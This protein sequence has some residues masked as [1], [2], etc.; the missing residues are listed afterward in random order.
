V[1]TLTSS[2][3][4]DTGAC[5][6]GYSG[7]CSYACSL[8]TWTEVTNTCSPNSC[9]AETDSN[10]VLALTT[11]GNTDTGTCAA[12]YT[13]ACSYSCNLGTWSQVTNTC[14]A[15]STFCI[16]PLGP[17]TGATC[18][19]SIARSPTGASTT[20]VGTYPPVPPPGLNPDGIAFDGTNMW[21]VDFST[22]QLTEYGPT[23]TTL[24]PYSIAGS[25]QIAIAFDGT[26]M[27][28]TAPGGGPSG[29]GV[30]EVNPSGVTINSFNV[31]SY[32]DAI[33]FD[34][35]NMWIANES[36]TPTGTVTELSPTGALLGT[37]NVGKQP[38][39]IAFDGTNMWVT[40]QASGSPGT[41]TKLSPTGVAIGTYG[42]GLEPSAIAFDGTNMW[43]TNFGGDTVTELSP[44]GVTLHT[45]DVGAT[46][47]AIA[48]DGV[49]LWVVNAGDDSVSIISP[50]TATVTATETMLGVTDP[51]GIAFDGTHM[52]ITGFTSN[53]VTEM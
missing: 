40:N 32:P 21:A 2:G 41:V 13:G 39:G 5:A 34:G 11:S 20:I 45:V 44:T 12:G 53:N 6:T 48:F 27:W 31:G 18:K 4:S 22:R 9:S 30:V 19:A 25:F 15:G 26:N 17:F 10:C 47:A 52:W 24:G 14:T 23:G 35:T 7:V 49:N 33:A 1:L 46:P 16:A 29:D 36:A 37:Y 51:S 50:T 8:G 43:V 28:V 38:T 42:V 3:M